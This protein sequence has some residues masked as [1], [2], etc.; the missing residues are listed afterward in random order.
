[1]VQL[2]LFGITS[3]FFK[4]IPAKDGFNSFYLQSVD[5]LALSSKQGYFLQRPIVFFDYPETRFEIKSFDPGQVIVDCETSTSDVLHLQ[6]NYYPGWTTFIDGKE[7]LPN[8]ELCSMSTPITEGRHAIRFEYHQ[9]A[10][11][12]LFLLSMLSGILLIG[13]LLYYRIRSI[14]SL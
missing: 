14:V 10:V 6:Q 5:D 8:H 9:N 1:M 12:Y 3:V 2:C 13:L 4:K 11:K 7:T